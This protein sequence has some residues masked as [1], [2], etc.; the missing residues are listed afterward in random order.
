MGLAD[1]TDRTVAKI[2]AGSYPKLLLLY[3]DF[4]AVPQTA[5]VFFGGSKMAKKCIFRGVATALI[6]PFGPD[7]IDYD[8]FGKIIDWQIDSGINGLV[9]CGTTGE[10]S[11]LSDDEHRDAIRFC[12]E[13]VAG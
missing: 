6:T 3:A 9:V 11:T 4:E 1:N 8:Q 5:F 7:G 13:K 10:A 2:F 12:V